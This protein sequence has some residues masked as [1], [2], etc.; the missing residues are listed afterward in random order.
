MIRILSRLLRPRLALLNGV[1][2]L[3]GCLL[4]PA[5]PVLTLWIAFWG[6]ALLAAGGSALNQVLERDQDQLMTRTKLRPLPSG[7]LTISSATTIGSAFILAGLVLLGSCG[8]TMPALLGAAALIWYLVIYTPLK[9]RT[10][11]ALA[12]GAVCGSVPPVI[13]WCT[14]GGNPADYRA[15]TLACLLYLW[16]IPH[17]W[18]FQR[19]YADDYR[20][21][22]M[23][24]FSFRGE[25][26]GL[27]GIFGVWAVALITAAMLLPA[28]G[29]IAP[30]AA[31]W[32][33]IF[34][35]PLLALSHFRSETALF[36]YLN[37]FPLLVTLT[38]SIR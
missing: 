16:Q 36:S 19:R 35:I 3:G 8:S 38:L 11:L 1:A 34:P 14:A 2:A 37:L 21:A 13:G 32:F 20:R 18:L 4:F 7:D 33:V 5:T 25:A 30:H 24:L 28:F 15:M 29:I 10:S 9:R 17:F 26:T 22:G 6:V 12:I 27:S 23:P 31:I